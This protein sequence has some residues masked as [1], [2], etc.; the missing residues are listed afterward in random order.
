M[1]VALAAIAWTTLRGPSGPGATRL[2]SSRPNEVRFEDTIES[3]GIGFTMGFLPNEQGPRFRINLYDHG[4]GVAVADVNGDGH[5]DVYFCNQ[6]GPNA[7]YV[8]DGKGHFT[9][10]TAAAGVGLDDRISVSATFADYDGDGDQDLY[11][12]TTRGGNSLFRNKGDGTFE[13]VTEKAGLTLVAHSESAAF[14]DAD[15]DG[16]LDLLVTNTA[17]WTTGEYDERAKYFVGPG[18]LFQMMGSPKELNRFYRNKGDGTFEDASEASGLAGLGWAGDVTVFDMD[19]D[20]DLDVF[21]GN[22]FGRSQLYRNDG[23][24]RFTEVTK[25]TLGRTSWGTVGSKA[26]DYDGDGRL[27]LYLTDMHSD[28]WMDA[29][30]DPQNIPEH[31]KFSSIYGPLVEMGLRTQQNADTDAEVLG[32]KVTEVV[33][34]STLF[35]AL[36]HGRF[37]ETSDQAGLET[38]WP[39]GIGTGDFD[40]DGS[41]DLYIASAM[42]YPYSYWRSPLLMNDGHGRFTDH[43]ASAGIDPPLGGT[44]LRRWMNGLQAS[45][46]SRSVAT[47]DFDHDGRLDLVVNNF[48]DR[49]YLLMNRSPKRSWVELRLVGAGADRDAVGALVKLTVDGRVL[50]R[51]VE[52]ATGYL[53]QSSH[54]LHFGLGDAKKIDR[55]E[56]RWPSGRTQTLDGPE[57]DGLR[58]VQEPTK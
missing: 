54:V 27:D 22:M 31:K 26:F 15:G 45:K 47:A 34:G 4:C 21:V 41:V 37:E 11:V 8:G 18:G 42:G 32:F 6:L 43:A 58:V 7:L 38:L 51:Q 50:V 56:I 19:E 29:R 1:V 14:F 55:M 13:D 57:I 53:A 52:T 33:F 35:H 10:V 36:G 30:D 46:S 39:W 23:K 2:G 12:A 49:P 40:G 16:D 3:S 24:G 20:G 44:N 48:N 17:R 5:D 28:M 25:E 9:D